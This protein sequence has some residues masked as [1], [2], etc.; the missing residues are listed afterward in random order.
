M[1]YQPP[2]TVGNFNLWIALAACGALAL[3]AG[4]VALVLWKSSVFIAPIVVRPRSSGR[5]HTWHRLFQRAF[6]TLFVRP[7]SRRRPV[8]LPKNRDGPG[9]RR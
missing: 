5:Q 6:E 7:T 9:V 2:K 8:L 4:I 3:G 1:R